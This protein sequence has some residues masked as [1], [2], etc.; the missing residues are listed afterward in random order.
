MYRGAGTVVESC[1][2]SPAVSS[3]ALTAAS[4]IVCARSRYRPLYRSVP[5]VKPRSYEYAAPAAT[6]APKKA[7]AAAYGRKRTA[8]CSSAS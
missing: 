7:S 1:T 6:P 8:T 2:R 4:P 5:P 3:R